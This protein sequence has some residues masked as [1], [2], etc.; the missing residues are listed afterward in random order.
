MCLDVILVDNLEEHVHN[1]LFDVTPQ[2]HKFTVNAVQNSLQ[3]VA[4]TWVL[5]V[6]KLEEA[7]DKVVRDMLDDHILAQ[8]DSEYELQKQL[9]DKLQVRPGL[10]EMRL[11]LIRVHVR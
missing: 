11:I 4:L 3:V 7:A 10:L 6:E 5:T 2:G 1:L 9:I 8:M